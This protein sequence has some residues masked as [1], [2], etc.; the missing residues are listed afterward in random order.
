MF[1]QSIYFTTLASETADRLFTNIAALGDPDRSFLSTL[2]ALLCKRLPQ[3]ETVRLTIKPIYISRESIESSS[4]TSNM[5]VMIPDGVKYPVASEYNIFIVYNTLSPESGEKMLEVIR[6][7]IGVGKRHMSSYTRQEDLRIFYARKL[8]ALFYTDD[9]KRNTVIFADRLELN[10]FHALQMMIPKYLPTLFDD[11]SLTE[12]ETALLKSTGYTS[13]F[14]YETLIEEFGKDIDIRTEIIR[15]KLSGFETTFERIRIDEIKCEI[16]KHRSDYDNYLSLLRELTQ[17]IQTCRYTLAGLECAVNK[18]SEDSEL[19][20]Y[21]MCNKNLT[22]INVIGTAIEFVAHGY[23]DIYDADAF[24]QYAGNHDGFMYS[25]L[26]LAVTKTQMEKLY[27][28]IFG[29]GIYKLRICAAYT[30]DMRTGIK[31]CKNYPFM[32]ENNTYFPNPH[33]QHFGCI[34]TY[35][36]RFMEYMQNKDYVGAIDQAVVSA[37]NLNFYDSAAIGYLANSLSGCLKKCIE[38]RDGTL[39]TPYEAIMELEGD[40]AV[41]QDPLF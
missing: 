20:D 6:E 5:S 1:T 7:N 31:A 22:I 23:A 4:L 8:N 36:M 30:A 12:T 41:C 32:H 9:K 37:R 18:N 25:N 27:R 26:S 29:E 28:A 33:I 14:E 15:T 24:E 11:N 19:M 39:L 17:K 34:G 16:G 35:E 21:F 38:K 10:H 2:R 40:E 3:N 13:A